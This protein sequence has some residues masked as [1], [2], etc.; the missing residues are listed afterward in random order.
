MRKLRCWR[1]A[2][3]EHLRVVGRPLGAAVPGAVVVG[4]VAVVLAVRL[5]VLLV[6]GDE[7]VQREAVVRGDE[8]DRRE[9]PPAVGL[10]EVAGAREPRGEVGDFRLAAP[11][12]AHRVAVD[13]VPLRPEHGEVADLVPARADVP[14][15]GDEL[16]LRE[17]GVLVDDVE[18]RAESRSTS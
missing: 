7:V 17:H 5:V 13:A 18:E 12:V 9:R 15:L 10:V 8:V 1:R 2:Q 4:P 3:L 14:R 16:H 11:E 6:V